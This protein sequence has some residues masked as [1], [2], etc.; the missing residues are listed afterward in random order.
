MLIRAGTPLQELVRVLDNRVS[1]TEVLLDKNPGSF[2]ILL[3]LRTHTAWTGSSV[4]TEQ[5]SGLGLF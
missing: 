4:C 1:G 5:A 3:Y 2:F